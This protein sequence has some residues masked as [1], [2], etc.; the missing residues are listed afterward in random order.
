MLA[1]GLFLAESDFSGFHLKSPEERLAIL[2]QAAH[3]SE[4]ECQLLSKGSLDIPTANRMIENVVGLHSLPLGIA[5]N[6]LVNQ[7]EYLIPMAI[8]EPSVVAAASFAAKLCRSSGGFSA[9]ATPPIMIGQ[10]QL[11]NVPSI[12]KAVVA[13]EKEKKEI[14]HY[15][16]TIDPM[17]LVKY[18]GGLREME[19]RTVKSVRGDFLVIHLLVDVCDAMGAN[20]I[21]TLVETLAPKF[22]KLSGGEVRLRIIS[23]LAI[24]RTAKAKAVW[25]KEE[26]E[27]STKGQFKGMEVVERILDAWAFADA[28]PFRAATH[29][30]GIMNGIDAASIATGNDWR[31]V[32][33]G[34]HAF[35][36][37]NGKYAPLTRYSKNKNNDLV[38]EIE[39]PMVVAT[40]GGA[41][42]THPSAKICQKILGVQSAAEMA[43]V[44]A[45]L[46]L[47]QN[48]AALRALS[49]EGIQR[50]H[51]R[52]HS[53]NLAVMAGARS[54]EIEIVAKQM[55][56]EGKVR[57]DRAKE[58]LDELRAK[59]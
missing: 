35:A 56:D 10:V 53:R 46:G 38:G 57:A 8:E 5:T 14:I 25:T 49:T 44:F 23:N 26:L 28:D 58:I 32:E 11:V 40:I 47:A 16:N 41:S 22:E 48:F 36:A 20:A 4:E 45:S 15:A 1:R 42:A 18:G 51:M 34:A 9:E 3:L 59:K 29:N 13:L 12:K 37:M 6:F 2:K 24:H 52:L 19:F 21:N 39:L 31:G 55:A 27:S 54:E 7:K 30:K 33:A 50:G 43:C 17:V